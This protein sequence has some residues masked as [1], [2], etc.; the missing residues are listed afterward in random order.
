VVVVEFCLYILCTG[1]CVKE[2]FSG[3]GIRRKRLGGLGLREIFGAP[4]EL[5]FFSR[6]PTEKLRW[7]KRVGDYGVD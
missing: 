7:A 2:G 3:P 6:S 1:M 5:R 4:N